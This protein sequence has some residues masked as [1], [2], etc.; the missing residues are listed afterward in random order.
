MVLI[1]RPDQRA[2]GAGE[3]A[4]ITTAAAVANAIYDATGVRVRQVPFR[5]ERVRNAVTR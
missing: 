2:V 1:D 4:T 5:P 3:P